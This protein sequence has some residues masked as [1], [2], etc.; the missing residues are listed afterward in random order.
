MAGSLEVRSDQDEEARDGNHQITRNWRF[1]LS[2]LV[3]RGKSPLCIEFTTYL[4][5]NLV[6]KAARVLGLDLLLDLPVAVRGEICFVSLVGRASA[7][8]EDSDNAT[9]PG[10]D[11]G[12]RVP[13][14]GIRKTCHASCRREDGDLDRGVLDAVFSI[15]ACE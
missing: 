11:D 13:S 8:S 2:L 9:I 4:L 7:A 5:D 3:C 15:G 12:P 6:E 1:L 14:N 10:E